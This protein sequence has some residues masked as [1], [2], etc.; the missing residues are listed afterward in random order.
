MTEGMTGLLVQALKRVRGK[1]GEPVIQLKTA[2]GG[3]KTHSMLALY[4][5][6]RGKVSADS[7]PAIKPVMERAGVTTLPRANVAVLVGTALDPTKAKRPI[8]FLVLQSIPFGVKWR[9]NWRNPLAVQ[10]CTTI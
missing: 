9:H 2:F 7:I 10:S 1:D 3:G 8:N 5:M 4:H 6:L